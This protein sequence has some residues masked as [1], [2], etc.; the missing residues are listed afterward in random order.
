MSLVNQMLK[1]IDKRHAASSTMP[2]SHHDL[3]GVIRSA[4]P[5]RTVLLGS[6]LVAALVVAG[7]VVLKGQSSSVV[8]VPTPVASSFPIVVASAPVQ[9]ASLPVVSKASVPS[10]SVQ[11]PQSAEQITAVAP[12]V[13]PALKSSPTLTANANAS[14]SVTRV[15]T[16][17]QRAENLYSDAVDRIRQG[18]NSDAQ[19]ALKRALSEYPLHHASRQLLARSLLETGQVDDAKTMLRD[20]LNL[21]PQRLDFYMALAQASLVSNDLEAAIKTMESG[22]PAASDNA[23]FHALLATLLQR[24]GRHDEA[25]QHFVTSLRKQPDSANVLLGLGI[26]LQEKKDKAS[27]A[28]AYQRAIELGLSPSLMQFAQDRLR[29]LNR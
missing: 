10:Q 26:S 2:A 7:V 13:L 27:A 11:R 16:A 4:F 17:E 15:L 22:L 18:Q 14:G 29:Q 8:A 23:E 20:G 1:D 21:A 19:G 25:I 9:T 5:W 12:P 28:E 24:N 6:G 3:Q